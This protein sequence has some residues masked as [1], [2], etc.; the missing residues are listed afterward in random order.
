M[1]K[2]NKKNK[3]KNNKGKKKWIVGVLAAMLLM[4]ICL[5]GFAL[6]NKK[7]TKQAETSVKITAGT[8]EE[9]LYASLTSV[10]GNEISCTVTAT[11]EE[12]AYEIPVGTK[13]ITKLGTETTFL[14][15]SEGNSV[16]LLLEQGTDIIKEVYITG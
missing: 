12:K 4:T 9:L 8:K 13:V 3:K 10:V 14:R 11:G 15:L 16:A 5:T 7:E 1:K 2:E 6:A